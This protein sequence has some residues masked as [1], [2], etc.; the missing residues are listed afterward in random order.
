MP[1]PNQLI[2]DFDAHSPDQASA[3]SD[4][5]T[6]IQ[7]AGPIPF[8]I[9]VSVRARQVYLRAVPG[10]GLVVTIPKRFPKREVPAIVESQR[11]WVE[12][13]LAELDAQVPEQFRH[14]P[15][16]SLPLLACDSTIVVEY[17]IPQGDYIQG[18]WQN[19]S[20]LLIEA[21]QSDKEAVAWCVAC[22]LKDRARQILGPW[23]ARLAVDHGFSYKRLMVRGQR[24][25][26]GSYSS[27]GTLSL[28]YKLLFLSPQLVNYVLLHEL[29]HTKHLDHSAAFWNLLDQQIPGA[30]GIDRQLRTAGNLVPPWLELAR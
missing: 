18:R 27:S 25:V 23:L 13:A 30:R 3:Q 17:L 16:R 15:P 22:A 14:W 1:D 28:N 2:L 9:K 5:L 11:N 7:P 29:A 24:S 10:R 6:P 19:E 8:S 26:W 12:Q 20:T 4:Q 21:D